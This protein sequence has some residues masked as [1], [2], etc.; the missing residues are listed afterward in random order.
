MEDYQA[1][2]IKDYLFHCAEKDAKELSADWFIPDLALR[3]LTKWQEEQ[4]ETFARYLTLW[5]EPSDSEY[6]HF[7]YAR[8]ILTELSDKQGT[9]LSNAIGTI[10]GAYGDV[11]GYIL[12]GKQ[13]HQNIHDQGYGDQLGRDVDWILD[14][15]TR[16]LNLVSDYIKALR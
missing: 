12:Y 9:P 2:L 10:T 14:L 13:P 1:E 16:K 5:K 15:Q 6:S 3:L 4:P 8:D 7:I 11:T